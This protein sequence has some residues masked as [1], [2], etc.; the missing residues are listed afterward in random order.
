MSEHCA[1]CSTSSDP[2]GKLLSLLEFKI[3]FSLVYSIVV[4]DAIFHT[5]STG[6]K[7]DFH[8]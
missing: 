3:I 1:L 6:V 2:L 4:I 5:H 7:L 8:R